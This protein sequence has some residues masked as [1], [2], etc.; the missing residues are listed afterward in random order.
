MSE[1]KLEM[2]TKLLDRVFSFLDS[3]S[4]LLVYQTLELDYGIKKSEVILKMR[5]FHD[6]LEDMFGSAAVLVIER[7]LLNA[8][9]PG[10]HRSK[11]NC[12][13]ACCGL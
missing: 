2:E 8:M 11:E 7:K 13:E 12:S 4:R 3:D 10:L 5:K 9:L 6:A 1:N